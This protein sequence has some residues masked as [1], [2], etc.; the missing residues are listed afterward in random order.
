M[1]STTPDP[2][3]RV[4]L[5]G[6]W[7]SL[8]LGAWLYA[9]FIPDPVAAQAAEPAA[10]EQAARMFD[11]GVAFAQEGSYEQ[12]VIAFEQAYALSRSPEVLYNL[13]MAYVATG[14]AVEASEALTRYLESEGAA[15][16]EAERARIGQELTRQR[17]RVGTLV[18]DVEPAQAQVTIDGHLLAA[19]V[20]RQ[21][22]RL[23][24]GDHWVQVSSAG[25]EPSTTTLTITGD[26]QSLAI[27][28]RPLGQHPH[29]RRGSAAANAREPG[30]EASAVRALR[31]SGYGLGAAGVLA[32]LSA[33]TIYLVGDSRHDDWKVENGQLVSLEAS[34]GDWSSSS[35]IA[36]YNERAERNNGRLRS[37]W[38]MD[39][40][41]TGLAIGG[42]ALLAAGIALIVWVSRSDARPRQSKISLRPA[43]LGVVANF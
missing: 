16:N 12:A 32:G 38:R 31:L 2:L 14:R 11:R 7:I 1:L 23:T 33:L 28:L 3:R 27:R 10:L 19:D 42:G 6:R 5:D 30:H 20:R 24:L 40:A 35:E 15:L 39:K 34:L 37:V 41:A 17:K 25:H 36:A 18:L 8:L 22:V 4:L 29:I 43:G 13:G 26:P 21:A 9:L